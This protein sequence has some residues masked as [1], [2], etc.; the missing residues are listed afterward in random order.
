MASNSG[1]TTELPSGQSKVSNTDEEF[2]SLKS[3][4]EEWIE[5]EHYATGG[6]TTSAGVHRLGSARAF[7]GTASQLS[8]PTG[9]NSG[10]IFW[11]TDTSEL[12]V[13]NASTSSWSVASDAIQLSSQQTWTALQEFTS[14]LSVSQLTVSGEMNVASVVTFDHDV[15]STSNATLSILSSGGLLMKVTAL[16]STPSLESQGHIVV[17]R[18][19]SNYELAIRWGDG[20]TDVIATGPTL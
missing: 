10:R 8:N 9:D 15:H 3:Y 20:T 18:G 1:W 11:V 19:G 13:G 17:R 16:H 14:G 6:S 2:R 12:R 7:V 4:V 5:T